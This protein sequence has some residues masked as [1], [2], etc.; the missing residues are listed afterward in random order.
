MRSVFE[1]NHVQVTGRGSQ[2]MVF[3]HGFG[4]DQRAWH[5]VAPHFESEFKVV[6]YDLTGAGRSRIAAYQ[7]DKYGSLR[8]HAADLL[9]ICR[10]LELSNALFIGHSAGAMIGALASIQ[11]PQLFRKLV[12]IGGSPRYIDDPP[13]VGGLP[14]AQVDELVGALARDYHAWCENVAPFATSEPKG[15]TLANELLSNF[16]RADPFVAHHFAKV[17]FYSD[18]R[19]DLVKVSRP[20]LIMQAD[21]DPFVPNAVADYMCAQIPHAQRVLIKARGGH[22]PHLGAPSEVRNALETFVRAP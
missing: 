5:R 3:A 12:L 7:A 13:Y 1:R 10:T 22:F 20:T 16:K 9:E 8:D 6:Q 4:V 21:N 19:A 2:A 15:S 18:H 14:Q 17:V 11:E